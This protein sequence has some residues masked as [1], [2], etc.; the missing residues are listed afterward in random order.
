MKHPFQGIQLCTNS[1]ANRTVENDRLITEI[2]SD[3]GKLAVL[4]ATFFAGWVATPGAADAAPLH[5]VCATDSGMTAVVIAAA[6]A[7]AVGGG[8]FTFFLCAVA[9]RGRR[10]EVD[11]PPP[12]DRPARPF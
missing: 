2:A 9:K 6:I 7:G 5:P 12:R 11:A 4:A 1:R 10:I 8:C 3:V